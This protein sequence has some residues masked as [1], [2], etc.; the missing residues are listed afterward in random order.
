MFS[1]VLH[2]KDKSETPVPSPHNKLDT[3]ARTPPP[4]GESTEAALQKTG[5]NEALRVL[6]QQSIQHWRGSLQTCANIF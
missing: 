2:T 6:K 4:R 1:E 5:S 3:T